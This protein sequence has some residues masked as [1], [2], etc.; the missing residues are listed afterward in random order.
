MESTMPPVLRAPLFLLDYDGTLAPIHQDPMLAYPHSDA[1][2]LLE[3]LNEQFPLWIVTG[4]HLNDLS[5]LLKIQLHAIGLHGLQ[6]GIIGEQ[7]R[8]T[9]SQGVQEDIKRMRSL[10]PEMDEMRVEEKEHTF[11]VHY[12]GASNEEPIVNAL[13]EWTG[14]LPGSLNA[15]WGKKVVE[16][17][18]KGIS[19]GSAIK[20]LLAQYPDRQ[21]LYIGDD[22]TDESAFEILHETASE[23]AVTIKVGDGETCATYRLPDVGSVIEYLKLYA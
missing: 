6:K 11:A 12:R 19:K 20:E 5:V 8:A 3:T 22:T 7:V 9:L 18:P 17:K 4:R 23:H 16:L 14:Y 21:P 2:P 15:I 13:K 1:L 10:L